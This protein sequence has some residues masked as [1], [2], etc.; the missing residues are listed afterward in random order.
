MWSLGWVVMIRLILY[1]IIIGYFVH[2]MYFGDSARFYRP[3]Q[4]VCIMVAALVVNLLILFLGRNS[5]WLDQCIAFTYAF[6]LTVLS[7]VIL[8]SGGF[9]SIFIPF[10]LP[11]LVMAAALLPRRLTALFP[12]IA[13][14]GIACIGAGYAQA[15][16]QDE[17]P[18]LTFYDPGILQTLPP[19]DWHT[20]VATMLI[21]TVLFFVVSYLSG[22]LSERIFIE[23]RLNEEVLSS[24]MEGVMVVAADGKVLYVNDEFLRLFPE[25]GAGGDLQSFA[26]TIFP[27]DDL[28]DLQS[29]QENK[30]DDALVIH[31][32]GNAETGRA[33]FEARVSGLRLGRDENFHGLL[34]LVSDLSLRKRM[35]KAERNLERTTAISTMA[36]GLA[37]EIRN[38]LASLRS[39]IQEIGESFPVD[40]Q[41][42][43][44]V[45]VVLSESD[46][47]DRVVGRF[48]DF[49]RE[50]RLRLKKRRLGGLLKEIVEVVRMR[51][52]AGNLDMHVTVKADPEVESDSDRLAEVFINLSLNSLQAL[53]GR[54]GR[55]DIGLDSKTENG[56][57]GV[58]ITFRD[59]GPGLTP[60]A[61]ERMFA[62]FFTEKPSGTGMGLAIARKQ[63]SLHG[64]ELEGKNRPEGGAEFR[65]WLPL[66]QTVN[67][68]HRHG[69]TTR[70]LMDRPNL[71]PG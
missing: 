56:T 34:F 30:R 3:G 45:G 6:D 50:E 44:L 35:E 53:D 42:R 52:D 27:A 19:A 67:A 54:S 21:L 10:Y 33:P 14:L 49:S 2:H 1:L 70:Y 23:Q 20:V 31:S 28:P 41:N 55:L 46:R 15:G 11:I 17:H 22:V 43:M 51:D 9:T 18:E 40:S 29:L 24:M 69:G 38:P 37:H 64:G 13:T 47:L 59:N 60:A 8:A 57:E 66:V 62:P 5:R 4:L 65:I 71:V 48:L 36:A 25:A 32:D 39:A 61:E 63:I 7:R 68:P 26:T 12:S 16:I 58:E